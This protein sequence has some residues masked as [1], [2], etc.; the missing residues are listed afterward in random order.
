LRGD[1]SS[2]A[3]ATSHRIPSTCAARLPHDRDKET[4]SREAAA[5]ATLS[6]QPRRIG[7]TQ[8][9]GGGCRGTRPR[10]R[11]HSARRQ[12]V[13]RRSADIPIPQ[14]I[15]PMKAAA[16]PLETR[17]AMPRQRLPSPSSPR[18][19]PADR[20]SVRAR[21]RP[22]RHS[23]WRVHRGSGS[24]A[25]RRRRHHRQPNRASKQHHRNDAQSLGLQAEADNGF[26]PAGTL[27]DF[28]MLIV[29]AWGGDDR[30]KK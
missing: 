12:V 18:R 19:C 1:F 27:I 22:P 21:G 28:V 30:V 17:A 11:W 25:R 26:A 23:P 9:R 8:P 29:A 7:H 15:M 6:R 14:R 4:G 13:A 2:R 16:A 3:R 10:R 24:A 5:P 20:K